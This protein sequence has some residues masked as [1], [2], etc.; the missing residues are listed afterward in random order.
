MTKI[1]LPA[2]LKQYNLDTNKL[3]T[4]IAKKEISN[5]S[6]TISLKSLL[7]NLSIPDTK[8]NQAIVG[9][10]LNH[11]LPIEQQ[12]ISELNDFITN[13]K[14]KQPLDLKIKIAL[15]LKQINMPLNQKFYDFFKNYMFS[16]AELKENITK[17]LEALSNQAANSNNS[18]SLKEIKTLAA[19]K[20]N[21][22][23]LNAILENLNLPQTK[24]NQAIVKQLINYKLDLNLE[25]FENLKSAQI[26]KDQSLMKL[27][28]AKKLNLENTNLLNQIQLSANDKL[29]DGLMKL[30]KLLMNSA[31]PKFAL[32]AKIKNL[33][34]QEP[35]LLLN[36]KNHSSTTE[37]ENLISKLDLSSSEKNSILK[38]A[39]K[40]EILETIITTDN[41]NT[42]SIKESINKLN[43]TKDNQLVKFLFNLSQEVSSEK[44]QKES[45]DLIKQLINLKSVNYETNN[46]LLFLP[47]LIEKSLELAQIKVD[48]EEQN[49]SEKKEA[50]KFSFKIETDKLDSIEV[51]I[52]TKNKNINM[53]FLTNNPETKKLIDNNLEIL[54]NSF[55]KR[56]FK[57]NYAACKIKEEEPDDK[58]ENSSFT[59]IDFTI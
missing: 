52:K 29:V 21:T 36:L 6:Q 23:N 5:N 13:L 16:T 7:K 27:A 37:F 10:L 19:S 56:D 22:A 43:L 12:L 38:N 39:V 35:Q 53:L 1:D 40:K 26:Q 49:S 42:A 46:T 55:K 3:S 4:N 18:I 57:I 17:L 47:V 11:N 20:A 59:T 32:V 45:R 58:K 24:E 54:E 41:I 50:L 15:L 48:E 28:F 8:T 25:N 2:T 44:F 33:F 31:N 30:S 14:D 34:K 9:E 51:R